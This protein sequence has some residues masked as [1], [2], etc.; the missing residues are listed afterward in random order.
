MNFLSG[1]QRL[2]LEA[3]VAGN[4]PSTVLGQTG[5]LDQLVRWYQSAYEDIQN[6]HH[7]WLFLRNDFSVA[8]AIGDN[9]QTYTDAAITSFGQWVPNSFRAYNTSI[10]V[11]DEHHLCDVE[12]DTFRQ[13]YVFGTQR[14]QT[15]TPIAITRKPDDSLMIYPIP[16]VAHTVVGEYFKAP[17]TLTSDTDSLIIPEKYQMIVV[18]RALMFFAAHN[19]EADKY[20]HGEREYKRILRK[21]SAHELPQIRWGGP[22]V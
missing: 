7:D 19:A 17:Q 3:G 4:G 9:V 22:F 11:S 15:G 16:D 10:G 12:W 14:T 5:E 20:S 1:V 6:I 18:W 21:M 8:F 13:F 2:R